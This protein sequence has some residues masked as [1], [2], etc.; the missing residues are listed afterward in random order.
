M[1]LSLSLGAKDGLPKLAI[2]HRTEE[3][4]HQHQHQHQQWAV[5]RPI[6]PRIRHN[7][8]AQQNLGRCATNNARNRPWWTP[9]GAE[10]S[11]ACK[12]LLALLYVCTV[13]VPLQ[14]AHRTHA[15]MTGHWWPPPTRRDHHSKTSSVRKHL[16]GRPIFRKPFA[17]RLLTPTLSDGVGQRP[18]ERT[19]RRQLRLANKHQ[20]DVHTAPLLDVTV[21]PSVREHSIHSAPQCGVYMR[22]T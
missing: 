22:G 13:G 15:H 19:S 20:I 21:G 11:R 6:A 18:I 17:S 12:E 1:H 14:Q 9:T 4:Q 7:V 5:A 2:F 16:A 10:T 8:R 3:H